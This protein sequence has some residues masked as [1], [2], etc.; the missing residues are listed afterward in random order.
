MAEMG[1]HQSIAGEVLKAAGKDAADA[2]I[3][4]AFDFGGQAE[5]ALGGAMAYN[6]VNT[7]YEGGTNLAAGDY[8]NATME[9]GTNAGQAAVSAG[10]LYGARWAARGIPGL[11]AVSLGYDIGSVAVKGGIAGFGAKWHNDEYNRM[12]SAFQDS[13]QGMDLEL[14]TMD[15]LMDLMKENRCK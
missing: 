14:G 3:G 8:F 6:S 13:I 10:R 5:W 11:N 7:F 12:S 15:D 9:I 1:G 4:Q 2:F